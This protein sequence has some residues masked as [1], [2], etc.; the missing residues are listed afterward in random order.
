MCYDVKKEWA[1]YG[2]WLVERVGFKRRG[3]TKLME[4]LHESPFLVYIDRDDDRVEDGKALRDDYCSE[5]RIPI[6]LFD[7][8][9][10][11]VLE[12]LVGLAIRVDNEWTGDPGEEH[13][14]VIF[15]EM[16]K[17]LG[18]DRYSNGRFRK[19]PAINILGRWIKREFERDGKGSIFPLKEPYYDQTQVEIWKQ[20]QEYVG[21]NY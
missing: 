15:W 16:L 6:Y 8:E 9:E 5:N 2:D 21:E 11:T 18:L 19:D 13:P 3:Y 7:Y 20:M 10:C 12:M 1:D 17:N 14:E 4:L